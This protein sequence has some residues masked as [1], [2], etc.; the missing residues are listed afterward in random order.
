[1]AQYKQAGEDYV[2]G[3]QPTLSD[4]QEAARNGVHTVIDF[5]VPKE[6]EH[7]NSELAR[8]AGLAYVNLPVDRDNLSQESIVQLEQALD[9]HAGPYLLHC[10]TGTRA[11]LMLVLVRA[12]QH[13][14]SAQRVFD[15]AEA[16]GF[17]LRSSEPFAKFVR[18]STPT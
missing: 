7:S 6:T 16:M 15:E 5:R 13:G 11:A 9:R 1:M 18:E 17:P 14:W 3:P 4:L 8:D 10:A 12:R 2:I